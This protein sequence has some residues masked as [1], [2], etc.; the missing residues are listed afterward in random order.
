MPKAGARRGGTFNDTIRAS[1]GLG[2]S[3]R[4]AMRDGIVVM[5]C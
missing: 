4:R 1:H 3:S 5:A 2:L